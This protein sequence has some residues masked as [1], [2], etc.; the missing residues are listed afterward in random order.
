MGNCMWLTLNFTD[1]VS[2]AYKLGHESNKLL[3]LICNIIEWSSYLFLDLFCIDSIDCW[4][5]NVI[6]G[7][8]HLTVICPATVQK[9]SGAEQRDL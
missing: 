3:S 4:E 5:L 2:F 1:I 9:Y 7:S 8:P 6:K